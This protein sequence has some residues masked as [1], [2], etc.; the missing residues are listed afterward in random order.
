ME[1]RASAVGQRVRYWRQRRN[2]DRKQLAD[3][4]G[5]STSWLDKIEKGERSL[6]RL[7]MLERVAEVLSIDPSV[8]TDSEVARSTAQCPDVVEV[9]EIKKALGRYPTLTAHKNDM[10]SV[11]MRQVDLQLDYAGNAWLSSHFTTVV[12]VLPQLLND[13]QLLAA[14]ADA[15]QTRIRE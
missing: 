4:V 12:R 2:L 14:Q 10:A 11:T 3:M 6:L 9:Q 1:D 13:A 8:L 15:H 7:P 5:R